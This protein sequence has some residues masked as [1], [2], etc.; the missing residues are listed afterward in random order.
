MNTLCYQCDQPDKNLCTSCAS[1][2]FYEL[3]NNSCVC[4]GGYF[5]AASSCL[6]CSTATLGC[7]ACTYNDLSNGT[8]AYNAALFACDACNNSANY[9]VNGRF[10]TLCTLNKCQQCGNLTACSACTT[11]YKLSVALT[12]VVCNVVGCQFCSTTNPNQCG[13]CDAVLGYYITAAL[14]C[15]TLCGDGIYVAGVEQCD[16]NNTA[17]YDGCSSTCTV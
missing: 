3:V 1:Y 7:L 6:P 17:N 13:I 11:G 8:L 14:G 12:C 16:D 9:F 10:C 5:A 2:Q 15:V 4:M